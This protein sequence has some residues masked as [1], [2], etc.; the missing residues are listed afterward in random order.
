MLT[1]EQIRAYRE[2]YGVGSARPT[3]PAQLD[4]SML[5]KLKNSPL[6]VA[7]K[8]YVSTLGKTYEAIPGKI[9]EDIKAG[10]EDIQKGNIF[11]GVVKS[12]ARVAG[13]VAEAIYA[14][15]STAIGKGVEEFSEA[16]PE[17][18][19]LY[20]K[21]R[22]K[23][24]D[25][26]SDIPEFQE[27]AM[28]HP[29][30]GE[31]FQRA[32][33]LI[34]AKGE[35]GKIEPKTVIERTRAQIDPITGK[36]IEVASKA[37]DIAGQGVE[38]ARAVASKVIR[39]PAELLQDYKSYRI[40]ENAPENLGSSAERLNE[41]SQKT[42]VEFSEGGY[43]AKQ[44]KSKSAK[45]SYQEFYEQE[46]KFKTDIKQDTAVGKVGE[47]IGNAYENVVRQRRIAGKRMEAEIAKVGKLQT[48]LAD[49]FPKL[50]QELFNS[51]VTYDAV[52]GKVSLTRTSKVTAQDQSI[53]QTYVKELNKL[54][55]E[56]T[57]A[58]LDAFMSR[59]PSE[60]DVYKAK[61]NVTKT[62]NGER[63]IK[64]HL[65]ELRK[66]LS[67]KNPALSEYAK[68]REDYAQLSGFLDEGSSFLGKKTSTGDFAKDASL[69]KSSIQSILNQGKKD[70]LLK[71]EAL[72]GYPAIDEAMLALQAM[73]N[74][75][76]FRGQSLL[77]LLSPKEG[78]VPRVPTGII[79]A[80]KMVGEKAFEYGE[81]KFMG[82][83]H[84]QTLRFLEDL[85]KGGKT[86]VPSQLP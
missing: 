77:D 28:K 1:P 48:D 53:L 82:T 57:V 66:S 59:I 7:G 65:A 60:I 61:N 14:P 75:G 45:E 51:G 9:S 13:D 15:I 43:K 81:K 76:N 47:R 54:G 8:D 49:S 37:K 85:E 67:G 46:Q 19:G 55:A 33:M 26:I 52:K 4:Q 68:A 58:E 80:A 83:S 64:G 39:R 72:T 10:A 56:P 17:I 16:N 12:G 84:E 20:E 70:W 32:L 50:E 22:D 2:K 40:R 5:D 79:D 38:G 42:P 3:A 73:K 62:T 25:F 44:P 30:A 36:V 6:A 41:I 71:L 23:V 34:M 35:K 18:V 86:K 74:S 69:A 31:D 21:G 78:K 63:I 11:K 29:N 27:F 24:A